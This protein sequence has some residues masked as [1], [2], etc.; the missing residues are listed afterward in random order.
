MPG[1][2]NCTSGVGLSLAAAPASNMARIYLPC[3]GQASANHRQKLAYALYGL[4]L[5]A[6]IACALS[7]SGH[8]A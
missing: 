6:S 7:M 8:T 4:T 1:K 2:F 3:N 5:W